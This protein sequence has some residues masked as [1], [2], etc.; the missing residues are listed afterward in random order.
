MASTCVDDATAAAIVEGEAQESERDAVLAHADTC[1]A[2]RQLLSEMARGRGG[3]D[4]ARGGPLARGTLLGRYVLI[5]VLGAGSMGVVYRA[6]DEDLDRSVALKV[7]RGANGGP[8]D[9]LLLLREARA[10]ARVAHPHVIRVF[11]VG[12]SRD[13]AFFAMELFEGVSL[14][15][16]RKRAHT[17]EEILSLFDRIG[18]GLAA[19]HDA[20]I[21]HRDFKPDNVLVAADGDV[22]ITDF[23][24]A[25]DL[26]RAPASGGAG[27]PAYMA[28]EQVDGRRVDSRADQFAFAAVLWELLYDAPPFAGSTVQTRRDAIDRGA[29][30]APPRAAGVPLR[31]HRAMLRSLDADPAAR[32]PSMRHLLAKLRTRRMSR[33]RW[34]MAT[35]AASV[36]LA[37]IAVFA[38]RRQP[39]APVDR[40]A[41]VGSRL[42]GVWDATRKQKVRA[43]LLGT[44]RPFAD[45]AWRASEFALDRYAADWTTAS[46]DACHAAPNGP[47]TPIAERRA[48]CVDRRLAW[49]AAT[50][51][52]LEGADATVAENAVRVTGA[53]E[54]PAS[55]ADLPAG[56]AIARAASDPAKRSRLGGLQ[57]LLAECSALRE[58]GGYARGIA[59]AERALAEARALGAA[60]EEAEALSWLGDLQ[61]RV[62]EIKAA[63]RTLVDAVRAAESSQDDAIKI[64]AIVTL[65][66]VVGVMLNRY[67]DG[68]DWARLGLATLQRGPRDPLLESRLL[69]SLG[70]IELWSGDR[71]AAIRSFER[72]LEDKELARA[73]A[74]D[75]IVSLISLAQAQNRKLR[76]DDARA[77][78]HRALSI[79]EAGFGAHHPLTAT[80]LN[81][82]AGSSVDRGAFDEAVVHAER[83]TAINHQLGDRRGAEIIRAEIHLALAYLGSGD[84]RRAEGAARLAMS[85]SDAIDPDVESGMQASTTLGRVLLEAGRANEARP[86][87]ERAAR[88]VD[89]HRPAEDPAHLLPLIALGR[90]ELAIHAPARARALLERAE[91]IAAKHPPA[92]IDVVELSSALALALAG[93]DPA[94]AEALRVRARGFAETLAEPGRKRAL[95]RLAREP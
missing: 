1:T 70:H 51:S 93:V 47:S 63:H 6:F 26:A 32:F 33:A 4:H 13:V 91:R 34:A 30:N 53:L 86:L 59:T 89:A 41:G 82:L 35:I 3:A 54:P 52:V 88:W 10:M 75:L 58:S 57:G 74:W 81:G 71:D 68:I 73:G 14:S 7:L 24:L 84:T 16:W 18:G 67:D 64:R 80:A 31:V 44:K 85:L 29:T 25:L 94:R 62:G 76:F 43:A 12:T 46:R 48:A 72:A 36:L 83:A 21:V 23:G 78:Y 11:D 8:D 38:L 65:S 39:A 49:L 95:A 27:T 90:A 5:D 28:P 69:T 77:S 42:A 9:R 79:A 40:C 45:D 61:S 17:A 92:P 20:G 56:A 60:S 50:V 37:A 19:A 22:K 87:L 66:M 2:C 55:C 15:Q